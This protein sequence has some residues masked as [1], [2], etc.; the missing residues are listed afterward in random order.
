MNIIEN[1]VSEVQAG[2]KIRV[3]GK[4][5]PLPNK[6]LTLYSLTYEGEKVDE[7]ELFRTH[8]KEVYHIQIR[9]AK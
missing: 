7:I 1:I 6:P 3:N 2:D 8:E 4:W 9:R 5:I